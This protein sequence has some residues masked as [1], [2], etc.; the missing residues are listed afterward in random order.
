M[1]SGGCGD[2]TVP[3]NRCCADIA[4]TP[5]T[6][7]IRNGGVFPVTFACNFRR[8][9]ERNSLMRQNKIALSAF[10]PESPSHNT[11]QRPAPQ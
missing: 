6:A 9:D 4:C 1:A 2:A 5:E 11:D 10:R 8:A 7:K 3:Q